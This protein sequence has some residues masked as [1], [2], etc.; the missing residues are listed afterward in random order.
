MSTR[1]RVVPFLLAVL[2]FAAGWV[3]AP[4]A[5]C[6]TPLQWQTKPVV[7]NHDRNRDSIDDSLLDPG[8]PF[9]G[10]EDTTFDVVLDLTRCPSPAD[11]NDFARFGRVLKRGRFLTFVAMSGVR[12]ADLP[13]LAQDP[14]VAMIERM[15]GFGPA[16]DI[17]VAAI[18]VRDSV[19]Y[20]ANLEALFP[21]FRG[22]GT[23]VAI[24]DS[25]VDDQDGP[26]PDPTHESFPPGKWVGGYDVNTG[27]VGDAD[28][29]FAHGTHV[30]GIAVGTGGSSGT[31]RG[32]APDAGLVECSTTFACGPP[33]WLDVIECFEQIL[34]N[35]STWSV[36]VVNLSLKQCD[37]AGN[38]IP[39]NGNDAVSQLANYL[40]S[41]GISVVAAAGNEGP[42]NVGLTA[43][44]S[45]D[46][47]I[48]VAGTNDQGTI[49]RSDDTLYASSSHGPRDDDGDTDTEDEMKPEISA[50]GVAIHSAQS[51]TASGYVD[52]TGT[53]MAS[54]HV[55]GAV[56][57]IKQLK[58]TINPGSVKSL[59]LST[60]E[61]LGPAG[62]DAEFG[63]GYLDVHA[64]FDA[65]A[66]ADP[67]YPGAGTYPESW[68][69]S[70]I[71]TDTAPEVGVATVI[72]T[73]VTNNNLTI[74]ALGVKVTFGVYIYSTGTPQFYSIG[75]TTVDVP[76]GSTVWLTQPWI[77][78]ASNSGDPHACLKSTIDYGQ[79]TSF[80]NNDCQRNISIKQV[81]SPAEFRFQ[82]ENTLAADAHVILEA[83][84]VLRFP[85]PL[86]GCTG[87]RLLPGERI[88]VPEFWQPSLSETQFDLR[89]DDCPREVSLTLDSR[90]APRPIEGAIWN[91]A[92]RGFTAGRAETVLGGVTAYA[93][94]PCPAAW[95]GDGDGDGICELF[96]NCP[97]RVNPEQVD[98]DGDRKGDVCDPQPHTSD[99]PLP[100]RCRWR[101]KTT[102][103][104]P[105]FRCLDPLR[106][107][108][109]R[110]FFATFEETLLSQ[111]VQA[112][113]DA[114]C[115][116]GV[117]Q[118]TARL[119]ALREF[120]AL[121]AEIG[122]L[123]SARAAEISA[124]AQ[125]CAAKLPASAGRF[126]RV[127]FSQVDATL[128]ATTV[129][130]SAWGS[131]DL[132]FA[133]TAA[134]QYFNLTVGA[135]WA[136]Q[137]LPILS[138]EGVGTMHTQTVNFPLGV[139]DGTR[140][141]AIAYGSSL[142]SAVVTLPPAGTQTATVGRRTVVI[143]SGEVG[144]TLQ[145]NTPA[146]LVGGPVAQ[147]GPTSAFN[148]GVPNQEAGL[149]ECVP[150][151]ISNSLQFLKK[152]GLGLDDADITIEKMKEATAWDAEDGAPLAPIPWW[153]LK[154]QYMQR[155]GL[156]VITATTTSL[157]GA[158][159]GL[160]MHCDVEMR[161]DIDNPRPGE[162]GGHVVVVTG[163]TKLASGD[164]VITV[165]HDTMQGEPGGTKSE[166][167]IYRSN[168][169]TIWDGSGINGSKLGRFVVECPADQG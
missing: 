160:D 63:H 3:A 126:H 148:S 34:L 57:L 4:A 65:T 32:V 83:K 30:A 12:L 125:V 73:H 39:Q 52:N 109:A 1:P 22:L 60:A 166:V 123:S 66:Q 68:L 37:T 50:P 149:N 43:P 40:V 7:W 112:A 154:D 9:L 8:G 24:V 167:V 96:D 146:P 138:N 28:D 169:G 157:E 132:T 102:D 15:R 141:D 16:L 119:D 77:P 153:D 142:T 25:G 14:R 127:A 85:A 29:L 46:N 106:H 143:A 113:Q 116:D 75:A 156:P 54:P 45:A 84:P 41:Q 162:P 76:P 5:A 93:H 23:T 147:T 10:S 152:R 51:D 104:Y 150:A 55:A 131:V 31:F 48:C 27:S 18:K 61:N 120:A 101:L 114:L 53:S 121:F 140:V 47:A 35:Q 134:I 100:A 80:A 78:Q 86:P 155:N 56:A 36:D 6:W 26:G 33:S 59:I 145:Y 13:I 129:L 98:S 122:A 161:V 128:D 17:S 99:V 42:S 74:P 2:T 158:L 21:T 70:D 115:D 139:Q 71:T 130:D 38:L 20:P 108:L 118:A 87:Y 11:L 103:L 81:N 163:L 92:A 94:P 111:K 72:H 136:V 137:N 44:C 159:A 91:V 107:R 64:A 168:D 151:A 135:V 117:Q 69:C 164:W 97:D 67:G 124:S 89:L 58:P 19:E 79:D 105:A 62:W 95:G 144:G 133:G 165:Q 90:N 82:V 110:P 49:D 88:Y